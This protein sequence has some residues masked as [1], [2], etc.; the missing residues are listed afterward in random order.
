MRKDGNRRSASLLLENRYEEC[1]IR[2]LRRCGS[3]RHRF[4]K[5]PTQKPQTSALK[6]HSTLTVGV[7]KVFSSERISNIWY[8]APRLR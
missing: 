5:V 7:H 6:L 4:T 3:M 1:L 2:T 8:T